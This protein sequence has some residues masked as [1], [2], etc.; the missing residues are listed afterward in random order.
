MSCSDYYDAGMD[1][2]AEMKEEEEMLKYQAEYYNKM[3]RYLEEYGDDY[4]TSDIVTYAETDANVDMETT[5]V[6]QINNY[7]C[8]A[9]MYL[10]CCCC[11]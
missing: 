7:I 4:D 3:E 1:H 11:C 5:C 6:D 9:C 2:L 8:E 10:L